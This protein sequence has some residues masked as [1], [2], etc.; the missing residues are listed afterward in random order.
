MGDSAVDAAAA[1]RACVD[2]AGVLT[3]TTPE[4]ALRGRA[5]VWIGE[6]VG[7]IEKLKKD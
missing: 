4:E 5:C 1:E 2:F 3:G 6:E 7:K